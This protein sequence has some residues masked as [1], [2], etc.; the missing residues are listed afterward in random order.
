[1]TY[2]LMRPITR[3]SACRRFA[4]LLAMLLAGWAGAE[5]KSQDAAT[6]QVLRKAQGV[7]RQLT[8]EKAALEAEKSSLITEK[9]A[10]QTAK[11]T[12]EERVK[13][14]E[15]ALKPLQ[16]LPA[17]LQR[18]KTGTESLLKTKADLEKRIAEGRAREEEAAHKL[19]DIAARARQ[20]QDDNSLLLEA[21]KEREQWIAIC[22][23]NNQDLVKA[24]SEA[25]T[26]L[27]DRSFWEE[28]AEAEPFTGIGKV[29]NHNA[30]RE[31]RYRIEHL[32][33]TPFQSEI[34]P[35]AAPDESAPEG[36]SGEETP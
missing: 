11:T 12:L 23:K 13:Q 4:L 26:K 8:E 35:P 17:E 2:S 18:C 21:V 32:K 1:M 15:A 29:K 20:I 3:P 27:R 19:R 9:D 16:L 30:A 5:P 36:G 28:V 25:V 31:Y 6:Q 14:L 24:A 22:G 7:V 34:K 10:L 33:A